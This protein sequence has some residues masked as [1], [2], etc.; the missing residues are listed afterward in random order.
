MLQLLVRA[1]W[2]PCVCS[3]GPSVAVFSSSLSAATS[4]CLCLPTGDDVFVAG[5][6][7]YR[8]AD[9]S[10]LLW[11]GNSPRERCCP[12]ILEQSEG[13]TTTFQSV[14]SDVGQS[15][16]SLQEVWGLVCLVCWGNFFPVSDMT[17]VFRRVKISLKADSVDVLGWRKTEAAVCP[18]IFLWPP[19]CP[20]PAWVCAD[21]VCVYGVGVFECGLCPPHVGRGGAVVKHTFALLSPVLQSCARSL[22]FC[23]PAYDTLLG[24]TAQAFSIILRAKTPYGVGWAF[25]KTALEVC[26]FKKCELLDTWLWS[27]FCGYLLWI[28]P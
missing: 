12:D 17:A 8:Q 14:V 28:A 9:P 19:P 22:S 27:L 11:A 3:R 1:V 13:T 10:H 20:S 23:F 25:T 6:L 26:L 24:L 7:V 18:V 5:W 15:L 2:D 4:C 21:S 16:F